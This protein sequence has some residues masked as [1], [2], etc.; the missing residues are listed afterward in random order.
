MS[1]KTFNFEIHFKQRS[2]SGVVFDRLHQAF[3]GP[4]LEHIVPMANAKADEL[5]GRYPAGGEVFWILD[6]VNENSVPEII[7]PE[8]DEDIFIDDFEGALDHLESDVEDTSE[9]APKTTKR[10]TTG[11]SKK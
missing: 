3:T 7:E 5:K 9:T 10:K 4:T 6:K 2:N 11:V 1:K 8:G